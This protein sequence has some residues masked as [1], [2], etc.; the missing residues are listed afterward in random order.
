[1]TC[2]SCKSRSANPTSGRYSLTCEA[3][4][5]ALVLSTRPDKRLASGMLAAIERQ[6]ENPGRERVLASVRR[7]LEKPH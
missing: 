6:P 1:M 5:V 7:S 3:C 4:C 2:E